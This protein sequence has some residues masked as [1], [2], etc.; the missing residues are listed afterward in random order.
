M[1]MLA[2]LARWYFR[3]TNTIKSEKEVADYFEGLNN[4]WE[5][6]EK[7]QKDGF[8]WKGELSWLDWNKTPAESLSTTSK[9]INCGDFMEMHEYL[10]RKLGIKSRKWLLEKNSRWSF[11]HT[12]HFVSTFDHLGRHMMQSDDKLR[13]LFDNDIMSMFPGQFDRITEITDSEG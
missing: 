13:E 4:S 3:K 10:Y 6:V 2:N 5:L 8:V 7:M 12:W 1:G 11:W 9:K